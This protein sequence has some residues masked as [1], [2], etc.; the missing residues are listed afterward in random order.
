MPLRRSTIAAALVCGSTLAITATT[1]Q[2]KAPR[3]AGTAVAPA[4][5]HGFRVVRSYPHD[6]QAFTQGL[7]F[8][9]GVLYESTGL[10]GRSGIRKVNLETGQVL[11]I[12][13]LDA[14][15]FGEGITVWKNR[16]VQLT[17]QSG[18]G[19]V[20]DR[21]TL[22]QQRTFRYSGEGW[23]LTHDGTRIIMSDGSDNGALRLLDP[24][25]LK[26][27]GTL[28]V[29]DGGRPV[30]KLNELEFVKG[31][32]YANVWQSERIAVISPASGRVTAWIDLHGLL[33]PR[34][35]AGVDVLN[36]IAYDAKGDRLFV[37]GKLWP[38]LFE[39]QVVKR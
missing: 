24:E 9:D 2:S 26:Q 12:Q 11:Q 8:V 5:V 10:N 31:Q 6:R 27:V 4:P 29:K 15:Y 23:G 35:A 28:M 36:G 16:I 38:R 21:Q 18:L 19:F 17:W 34:E 22:Q 3:P 33:D 13:P 32:I 7:E 37:T 14:S 39:I 20:Y 30:G 1:E 25:S